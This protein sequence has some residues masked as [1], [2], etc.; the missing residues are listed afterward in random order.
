MESGSG[1]AG[2]QRAAASTDQLLPYVPRLVADWAVSRPEERWTPF[3]GTMVFADLSGFTA[4]SERLARLG[5]VGAEEVTDAIGTCFEELLRVAYDVGGGLLKFGG[6]ALLLAFSGHDHRRRAV[7]S[8]A[9]MRE[10]LRTVGKLKTAAGNV[11]LRMSVG[12]HSGTY[13]CFLVGEP[14]RELLVTGDAMSQ[15]I[16]MEH[17]AS[18]GQIVLSPAT[19]TGLPPEWIGEPVGPGFLLRRAPNRPD[20]RATDFPDPGAVDVRSCLPVAVAEHV[21]A[22]GG[23]PEHRTVTVGFVHFDGLDERLATDGPA[24]TALALDELVT[25]VADACS[26]HDVA[27]LAT[28]CD[29]DG[30]KFV[31]AAGAPTVLGHDEERMVATARRIVDADIAIPVRV[32]VNRG[33]V[34]AGDVGP[35]Y[36][37]TYTVMGDTVNLAARLMAAAAPGQV[38][39]SG[40]VID[41]AP[42]FVTTALPPMKLKGKRDLIQAYAVGA[43]VSDRLDTDAPAGHELPFV[44]RRKELEQLLALVDHARGGTGAFVRLV[45]P[46]GIGKSRMVAEMRERAADVRS[47]RIVCEVYASS[48]PYATISR[49]VR[50][51]IGVPSGAD[52]ATTSAALREAIDTNAPELRPWQPLVAEVVGVPAE[53]TPES[54]SLAPQF[55]AARVAATVAEL[56]AAQLTGPSIIVVDDGDWIDDASREVLEVLAPLAELAGIVVILCAPDDAAESAA[57]SIALGPLARDEVEDALQRATEH[58]PLRPHEMSALA[59][60]ADGNPLFLTELWRA[61]SDGDEAGALPDSVEA[62]VTAQLDRLPPALR[63]VL[64]HAAILG[65]SFD[66][67]ECSALLE[68]DQH[69]GPATWQALSEFL[70]FEEN[71]RAQFRHALFRDTAYE[72]LPFR[73]RRQLHERAARAIERRL[74]LARDGE[75][76]LLSLHFFHAQAYPETWHYA[77]LAG[78]RAREKY[79]NVDAATL[80]ERALTAARRLPELEAGEVAVVREALGDVRD[81]NGE[82]EAALVNYRIARRLV[83]GDT[84]REAELFLKEAWIPERIGRYSDSVRALRKGL[85]LVNDLPGAAAA[86]VRAKLAT[87]Y[88]AIRQGQGREHEAITWSEMGITDARAAHDLDAEAHALLVRDWAYITLGELEKVASLGRAYDLYAQLNDLSGQGLIRNTQGIAAYYAGDWLTA[89]QLYGESYDLYMRAGSSVDAARSAANIG[90]V[91]SD[92]VHYAEAERRLLDALRVA[93]AAGYGVDAAAALAFLGRTASRAGRY[94]EADHYFAEARQMHVDG[95]LPADVLR[96]DAWAAESRLARG[97]ARD[98]LATVTDLRARVDVVGATT[99]ISLLERLRGLALAQLGQVEEARAAI[100]ESIETARSRGADY[101]VARGLDALLTTPALRATVDDVETLTKERDALFVRLDVA[102]AT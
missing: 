76:E 5:R 83:R 32:G 20:V 59:G 85:R 6:D 55:R 88:A 34:F 41:R 51:G 58:A 100:D 4:M 9:A 53:P 81:R 25:A 2:A 26:M 16:A 13:D 75:A 23:A 39:A 7:W 8:A 22:G 65:R 74:G 42:A 78:D 63:T 44:G 101:D 40:P 82:Y 96:V 48:T 12:V 73:R 70:L 46:A 37:R 71:D 38:V 15:L 49:I 91:L 99:E 90:E 3:R 77:R 43:A 27:L 94:D 72:K 98:V 66:R 87:W 45:G 86:R 19:A 21:L 60:R 10:R 62:L 33:W 84:V 24:A 92:Q 79:A 29:A 31:L 14:T 18:A 35:R 11:T 69:V 61:A 97:D 89:V 1:D 80:F 68:P 56:I 36:R 17:D 67:S 47:V 30:G 93:R 57:Q 28:D 52:D 54:A 64:G 95:E 102:P 50:A